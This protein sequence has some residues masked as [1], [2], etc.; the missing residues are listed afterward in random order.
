MLPL[1]GKMAPALR[2]VAQIAPPGVAHRLFVTRLSSMAFIQH[3][4]YQHGVYQH[5]AYTTR[6]TP[7]DWRYL[8]HNRGNEVGV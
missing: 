4:V 2:V 1:G 8:S 5:G 6:L 7:P 3:G